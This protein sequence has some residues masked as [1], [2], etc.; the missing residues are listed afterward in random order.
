MPY[1][2]HNAGKVGHDD[3]LR[4]PGIDAFLS[5]CDHLR[6]PSEEELLQIVAEFAPAPTD[7]DRA[8]PALVVA[9]GGSRYEAPRSYTPARGSAT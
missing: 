3:L 5:A 9:S 4:N 8:L 6:E 1:S 7:Q 2:G